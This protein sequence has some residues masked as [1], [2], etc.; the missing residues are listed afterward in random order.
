MAP[1]SGVRLGVSMSYGDLLFALAGAIGFCERLANREKIAF[2]WVYL[3]AGL[4]LVLSYVPNQVS[5]EPMTVHEYIEFVNSCI[6]NHVEI[7]FS[8]G[9][10]FKTI[11]LSLLVFPQVF[12]LLRIRDIAE[13]RT[14]VLIWTLGSFYGAGFTVLYCWGYIPGHEDWYWAV[15]HRARGLT[16]H[17]NAMALNCALGLPGVLLLFLEARSIFLRIAAVAMGLVIWRAINYSGSRTAIYTS[18]LMGIVVFVLMY[19]DMSSRTRLRLIGLAV[20]ALSAYIVV[21][22]FMGPATEYSAA[23]RLENG[24]HVSDTIRSH[25]QDLALDGFFDA[26]IFGQGFQWLRIAHNMYLQILH[27]SGMVGLTG[28]LGA[29]LFPFYLAFRSGF[30][31]HNGSSRVL[32]NC[33]LTTAIGVLIAGWA[34][35]NIN[36]VNPTIPFGMLLYIS[37]MRLD[38]DERRRPVGAM[39]P[40]NVHG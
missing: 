25:D 36:S 15:I 39:L 37:A 35:T 30:L 3:L 22:Y 8:Q 38:W 14:M 2:F 20:V 7:E 10:N 28:Y 31:L 16:G 24:S 33:L 4:L 12:L 13:V 27:S 9:P 32:K 21:K 18:M 1:L 5:P 17:P 26:P 11:F 34:L 40:A 23:W 29:L 19:R 6:N